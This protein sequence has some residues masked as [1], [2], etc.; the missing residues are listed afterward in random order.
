MA[1]QP[2]EGSTPSKDYYEILHLDPGAEAGIVDQAYWH[3]AR[4]HNAASLTDPSARARLDDLNE[5]YHVLRSSVLRR[6]YDQDRGAEALPLQSER[7]AQPVEPGEGENPP[8]P[9]RPR[10]SI[11]R[12]SMSTRQGAVGG[13]LILVL[14][15]AALA[16]GAQPLLVVALLI[17]GL[18]FAVVP[19]VG[20]PLRLLTRP[21]LYLRSLRTLRLPERPTRPTVDPD[22]LRQATEAMRARWRAGSE[23]LSTTPSP[24]PPLREELSPDRADDEATSAR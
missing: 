1:R 2:T 23:G 22:T 18:A 19:L 13:L 21:E 10:L 8:P 17:S 4:R 6:Q 24:D 14:A 7:E 5:A 15:S 12:L 11:R 16:A 3:L 20:K 9:S